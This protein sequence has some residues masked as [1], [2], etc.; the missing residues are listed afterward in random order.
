M[1]NPPA[2]MKP[3]QAD[4]NAPAQSPQP[5]PA[6]AETKP[7]K[8]AWPSLTPEL[9]EACK[10][11][12]E[13]FP[14]YKYESCGKT[15][16]FRPLRGHEWQSLLTKWRGE[17]QAAAQGTGAASTASSQDEDTCRVALIWPNV[18][19]WDGLEAGH[20]SAIAALARQRSGFSVVTESG[21][22]TGETL[23]VETLHEAEAAKSLPLP[24]GEELAALRAASPTGR[25]LRAQFPS[26]AYYLFAPVSRSR[27]TELQVRLRDDRTLD[28]SQE[29]CQEGVLWPL[30]ADFSESLAGYVDQLSDLIMNESGFSIAPIVTEL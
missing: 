25:I 24:E 27:W 29:V 23:K 6:P 3:L 28:V 21:R 16:V 14:V 8:E 11:Y 4:P 10:K 5:T 26:G 18:Q 15:F 19:S 9:I 12:A 7:E 20:P 2:D 1:S 13:G 30:D 17:D 22:I